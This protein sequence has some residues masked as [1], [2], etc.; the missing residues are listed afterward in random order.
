M[1]RTI[2]RRLLVV[3]AAVCVGV[4]VQAMPAF[5]ADTFTPNPVTLTLQAGASMNVNKTLHLDALPGA[6]DIIIAIDTT[7][8]MTAAIAQAK[9][10]ATALCNNVQSTIPGARFAVIDFRDVPD[11]PATNGVLIL[12]PTFTSS[13]A[14]VQAAINLM[15]AGGGGDFAEAYNWV[16]HNAYSEATLDASRNPN[17]VQFL[18]VLGDAPPHNSPAPTVAPSCGN[19][20]PADAGIT[21]DSEIAGLN[22]N[23]ITLLMIHFSTPVNI[24]IACYNE[25]TGATGGTAV[26]SGGDLSG[27]IISQIQAAAAHIDSVN[28][29]VSGACPPV[30]L[31]FSPTPPYGPFTAPVNIPFVET[32]TAPTVPG[33]YA[34]Q[35]TAVVDG[36]PRAVQQINL[37]V[38]PGNPATLTL[39]PKTDTNTVDDTHCVTATVKDAFLNPTPGIHVVFTVT[40]AVNTSGNVVTNGSGQAQFCYTGPALPGVDAISAF[41]DT[42]NNGSQNTGEPGDTASKTWVVPASTAGCKVTNGGRITAKNGDKATFGGNAVADG[43][44]GEEEYQD[45]GPAQ[46]MNVHSIDI[47]AVVCNAA[48]TSASIFGTATVN[49]GGSFD[50][51]IDVADNGE[52]GRNDTY[53]IRLSNA[54]D[55]GV[56]TLSA[57]GNVQ[58]H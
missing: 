38:T 10:Q 11:R 16:F 52:P 43:L 28:F 9:A 46:A 54:Y 3:G 15:S 23:D 8:S 4:L 26:E 39:A 2:L 37:T 49:G 19:Q 31:T 12:T 33:V 17:A 36:T 51:R 58:I 32:I 55:S 24:P 27:E 56:Q 42:N 45:H 35:V 20:P 44:S 14:V 53:R 41:A 21:S 48:G 1:S 47:T 6:A 57:G 30:G 22:A 50:F 18:V 5:G 29:V 13:C 7:G 25:L 40:G 34:C